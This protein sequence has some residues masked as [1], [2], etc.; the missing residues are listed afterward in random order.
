[1]H[2]VLTAK[3]E[4]EEVERRKEDEEKRNKR[5]ECEFKTCKN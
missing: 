2:S 5:R 4:H 3:I 1:M